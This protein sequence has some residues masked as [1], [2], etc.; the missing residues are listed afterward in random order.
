MPKARKDK[1]IMKKGVDKIKDDDHEKN[2]KITRKSSSSIAP[3][4]IEFRRERNIGH[5]KVSKAHI[6]GQMNRSLPTLVKPRKIQ[7]VK[8]AAKTENF[9][10]HSQ[11]VFRYD[12]YLNI[13]MTAMVQQL[14]SCM[15]ELRGREAR[16]ARGRGAHNPRHLPAEIARIP[17]RT[18]QKNA[19]FTPMLLIFYGSPLIHFHYVP[20]SIFLFRVNLYRDLFR[21]CPSP[22]FSSRS[23]PNNSCYDFASQFR[24]PKHS[25]KPVSAEGQGP[26]FASRTVGRMM[27]PAGGPS[28]C[29]SS[30]HFIRPSSMTEVMGASS[31]WPE[32]SSSGAGGLRT[33]RRSLIAVRS[34]LLE[35]LGRSSYRFGG[36]SRLWRRTIQPGPSL[37]WPTRTTAP[38]ASVARGRGKNQQRP[39]L[40]R[41]PRSTRIWR[42]PARPFTSRPTQAGGM[43]S[44]RTKR[45]SPQIWE[46]SGRLS[47]WRR[48]IRR[49][50]KQRR[51]RQR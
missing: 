28:P 16:G 26:L 15:Q 6:L 7:Q 3:S 47:P 49:G 39:T 30:M 44:T 27:S 36:R 20:P 41:P 19:R 25:L 38:A 48:W 42:K 22:Q 8:Y 35:N 13:W 12:R 9:E 10:K 31:L 40:T 4:K 45:C 14:Y 33:A 32:Y 23:P 50:R 17:G 51:E 11:S 5:Q 24:S 21:S 37:R 1:E 2:S 43:W 29:P 34:R 18:G 46:E